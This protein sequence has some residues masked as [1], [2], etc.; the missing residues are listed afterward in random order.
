MCCRGALRW[1]T[2]TSASTTSTTS[3]SRVPFYRLTEVLRDH[4]AL[5]QAQRLTLRENLH[6]LRLHLWDESR[7]SSVLRRSPPPDACLSAANARRQ[8]WPLASVRR[9]R[10]WAM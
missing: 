6:C 2:G 4:P 8:G 1:L 3:Q 7:A 9:R 10:A 5:E